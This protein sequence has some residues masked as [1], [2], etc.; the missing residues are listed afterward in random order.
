MNDS[1]LTV[2]YCGPIARPGEPARG[3]FE[4]ANRRLVGDLRRAGLTVVELPYPAV[5]E[6]R[7]AKLV[8]YGLGFAGLAA[9]ILAMGGRWDIF[10]ITP[11]RDQFAL[12]EAL[13]CRLARLRGAGLVVDLRAGTL[14]DSLA[15]PRAAQRNSL[16]AMLRMADLICMEGLDYRPLVAP[17][18][19][20][21]LYLPNYVDGASIGGG[22][23]P[24][25]SRI[26][27]VFLG[28]IV[29][30]KGVAVALDCLRSL[31]QRGFDAH[32]DVIG[33]GESGYVDRLK[34]EAADLPVQW[35]G[36]VPHPQVQT[37]LARSH[38]F[39]FPS[40]HYGEGHSNA[41][42]EAMSQGLVPIASDNGFNR[43]VV[44]EGG[45]VLG[46]SA[47]GTDYA[48]AIAG[49]LEAGSWTELSSTARQRVADNYVGQKL[50]PAL[51]AR[52]RS[53]VA[54]APTP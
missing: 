9:R 12:P 38:F 30:E 52:Y 15:S 33:T 42:T 34:H 14:E 49:V 54:K 36:A 43:S 39:L 17:F 31:G 35:L 37:L 22:A 51:I 50:V 2:A 8:A 3:G 48:D 27:L 25:G 19:L 32:L 10:H 6:S 21:P 5:P 46:K 47:A 18:T 45:V 4:A 53:L 7:L 24:P 44:A 11:L 20:D 28:R 29:P 13:L 26:N 23:E 1:T 40:L 16:L 41:L